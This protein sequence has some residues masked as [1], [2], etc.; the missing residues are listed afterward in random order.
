[1][2]IER[3]NKQLKELLTANDYIFLKDL[4]CF[5]ETM[6]CHKSSGFTTDHPKIQN[7]T[8]ILVGGR[9]TRSQNEK[10]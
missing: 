2:T 4:S 9:K 1:M 8:K 5:N 6:W 10:I 3:P 7:I